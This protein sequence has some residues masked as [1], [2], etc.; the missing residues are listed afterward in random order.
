MPTT[1]ACPASTPPPLSMAK[2][3]IYHR[4]WM[5]TGTRKANQDFSWRR[6]GSWDRGS[7]QSWSTFLLFDRRLLGLLADRCLIASVSYRVD[8]RILVA[9]ALQG[10]LSFRIGFSDEGK[11]AQQVREHLLDNHGIFDA[12]NDLDGATAMSAALCRAAFGSMLNTFFLNVSCGHF[13]DYQDPYARSAA[14]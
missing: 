2:H 10:R 3:R 12:G 8:H 1:A 7:S 9:T 13:A 6:C 5:V 14:L 4:I 11:L